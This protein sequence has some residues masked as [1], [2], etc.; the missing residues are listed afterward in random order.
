ML[1]GREPLPLVLALVADGRVEL[2]G[3][4]ADLEVYRGVAVCRCGIVGEGEVKSVAQLLD[5]SAV[6]A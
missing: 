2:E 6:L 1:V 3:R 4:E 5:V